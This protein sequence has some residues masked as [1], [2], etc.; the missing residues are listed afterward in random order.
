MATRS[1]IEQSLAAGE[2]IAG[3]M[4]KAGKASKG[5]NVEKFARQLGKIAAG[6]SKFLSGVASIISFVLMFLPSEA[7]MLHKELLQRFDKID[8]KLESISNKLEHLPKTIKWVNVK[9]KY[10]D[11]VHSIKIFQ[12]KL[13]QLANSES[14]EAKRQDILRTYYGSYDAAGER[15]F[16]LFMGTTIID[17]YFNYTKWDRTAVL[18]FMASSLQYLIAAGEIE[19]AILQLKNVKTDYNPPIT[20]QE[21]K[22][23][24]Q[25]EIKYMTDRVNKV[26]Q[27][28]AKWDKWASTD[29]VVVERSHKDVS[30]F[31]TAQSVLGNPLDTQELINTIKG[32]LERKYFWRKWAVISVSEKGFDTYY[33]F[34]KNKY[35]WFKKMDSDKQTYIIVVNYAIDSDTNCQDGLDKF[36][37][38]HQAIE[39]TEGEWRHDCRKYPNEKYIPCGQMMCDARDRIQNEIKSNGFA[40]TIYD[41]RD[42]TKRVDL[43]VY[44]DA[45]L[46]A[47]ASKYSLGY[48]LKLNTCRFCNYYNHYGKS[49]AAYTFC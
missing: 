12:R 6:A 49:F 39:W 29:Y 37:S 15:L 13:G 40:M 1:T 25:G 21:K 48:V 14:K 45:G 42:W 7:E 22:T 30:E 34:T 17:D 3:I 35:V 16:E 20:E 43:D 24:I 44:A 38:K 19:I 9:Q 41:D 11:H 36:K 31:M 23:R 33:C 5:K 32:N 18:E 47:D 26:E 4:A 46:Y 28:M 8:V 2:H 27:K 10:N